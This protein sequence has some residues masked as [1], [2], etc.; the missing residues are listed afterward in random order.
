MPEVRVR[1]KQ[2]SRF[3]TKEIAARIQTS[4]ASE[5]GSNGYATSDAREV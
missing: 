5:G 2:E 1:M 4:S 3:K